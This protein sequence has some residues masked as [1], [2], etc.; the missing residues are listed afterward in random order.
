MATRLDM[1]K[2]LTEMNQTK[3]MQNQFKFSMQLDQACLL[4]IKHEDIMQYDFMAET[5]KT[6]LELGINKLSV[7]LKVATYIYKKLD[8]HMRFIYP[9]VF[10]AYFVSDIAYLN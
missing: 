8:M 9:A 10:T 1:L 6:I 3:H 7:K 5:S 2:Y 4:Y